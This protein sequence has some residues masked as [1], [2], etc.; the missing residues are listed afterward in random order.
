MKLILSDRPLNIPIQDRDKIH[1][2]DLSS[3][4][5]ANCTGCFSCWT[6]TPGRCIIR[7]D[8]TQVYPRIA[9]SDTVLYVSRLKYGSYDTVMKTMLERAIPIQQAFIRIHHGE[10]HH[11]QRAV[12]SK[13]ATII[14]YGAEDK[15]EY[16]IFRQLVSRNAHNMNFEHY[17][18]LFTTESMVDDMVKYVLENGKILILNGSPRAPKSNSKRYAEIFTRHCPDETVYQNITKRNHQEL[19]AAME[20]Y[21]DVLFVF[22]LYADSLPVGLLNFLKTLEA[23]PPASKPV[24]SI[25]INCGFLEY[26]QNEVAIRIMHFSAVATVLPLVPY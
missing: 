23:N 25:L 16:S 13:K 12:A 2:I 8:A 10:T 24:I 18:I 3:L 20:G 1:Y 14:A 5:I 4:K 21:T 22:P 17:E 9:E 11:V 19:C 15:E 7:D 6:K 26:E